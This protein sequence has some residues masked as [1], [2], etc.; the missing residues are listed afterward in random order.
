M[1]NKTKSELNTL[2]NDNLV[3]FSNILPEKHREINEEIIKKLPPKK[4]IF[5]ISILNT[6]IATYFDPSGLGRINLE[7]EGYAICNGN[8]NTDDV[9]GMFLLNYKPGVGGYALKAVGGE[10]EHILTIPEIPSHTHGVMPTA[11]L[12]NP[13][14]QTSEP[15]EGTGGANNITGATGGGL[16]HNNMPPYFVVL[17]IM[18]VVV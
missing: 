12:G 15:L 5:Q 13:V 6:E 11:G 7:Y 3:D 14:L 16:A 17:P 18:E 10:K 1:P 8:N 4:A 9:L 2:S